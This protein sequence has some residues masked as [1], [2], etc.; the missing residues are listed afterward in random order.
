MFALHEQEE[1]NTMGNDP[2]SDKPGIS[3]SDYYQMWRTGMLTENVRIELIDGKIIY[4]TPSGG[5]HSWV[6]RKLTK[7]L[8]IG[9][10]DLADVSVQLPVRLDTFNEPEPDLALLKPGLALEEPDAPGPQDVLLV[11]EVS[12][13]TLQRD[14]TEK[15]KLY[16]RANIPVYWIFNLIDNQVEVYSSPKGDQYQSKSIIPRK[17]TLTFSSLGLTLSV[18]SILD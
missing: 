16:A 9:C 13:T 4:M 15:H 1:V 2:Q 10:K 8:V 5:R 14:Q 17:G 3:V 12:N 7:Q 11:I 6:I 18:E